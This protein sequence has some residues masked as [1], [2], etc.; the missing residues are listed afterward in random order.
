MDY[1]YFI[2]MANAKKLWHELVEFQRYPHLAPINE[3]KF[4]KMENNFKQYNTVKANK[5]IRKPV[6]N[7]EVNEI[8]HQLTNCVSGLKRFLIN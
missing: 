5:V 3:I 6:V 7:K 8:N 4:R 2:F 1:T